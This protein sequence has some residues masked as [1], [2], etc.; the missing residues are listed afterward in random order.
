MQWKYGTT[1]HVSKV[2]ASGVADEF[3]SCLP[4]HDLDT[5]SVD[6]P[7]LPSVHSPGSGDPLGTADTEVA[8]IDLYTLSTSV[9]VSHVDN[10]TT[11]VAL[12]SLGFIG[13]SPFNPSVAVSVK[14]LELYRVLRRRKAS[15]SVEG[16]VKVICDLYAV[17]YS[18]FFFLC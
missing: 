1:C 15:F 16:F 8:V 5:P 11:A 9:K 14:T 6:A 13:N 7:S 18:C 4:T 17:G 3:A 2:S 12:A 10:K